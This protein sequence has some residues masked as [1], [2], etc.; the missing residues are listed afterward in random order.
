M[1]I[2]SKVRERM[3]PALKR[4]GPVILQQRARDV[5]EA[6]TVTVVKDVLSEAFGYDKYAELTSE[7]SIRGTYCDLAVKLSDKLALLIEV[8]AA[9][10]EL[11]DRHVKQA[12]DYACNQGIEWVILTN[13]S[14][15]RL[16]QVIFAKPIDKRLLLD[17]DLPTAD[18]RKDATLDQ[19]FTFTKEGFIKGAQVELRDRQDA[20]SRYTI[21]ALVANN[22]AVVSAI[23][24]ELRRV[25]D[26]LV[27]ED[28]L[29]R[30]LRD[31]VI[32]RDALEGPSAEAAARRVNRCESK[33][34]QARAAKIAAATPIPESAMLS[35][36]ADAPV[37]STPDPK[38][39][40]PEQ[41]AT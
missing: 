22:D 39:A 16:Y 35:A 31:E 2:P 15:W 36:P 11:D 1:S 6:D 10:V 18:L 32:K 4:L 40:V 3:V 30:V 33:V 8:K 9:G 38:P 27:D 14:T 5:S 12:V 28:E 24:R 34:K 19:L 20:T 17:I 29:V 41:P 26:V 25:V 23:R 13:S 7:H 37:A 21:A